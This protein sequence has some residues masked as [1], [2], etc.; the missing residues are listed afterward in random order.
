MNII[1]NDFEIPVFD[2]Y[3]STTKNKRQTLRAGALYASMT[4]SGSTIYGIF[5]KSTLPEIFEFENARQTLS[6]D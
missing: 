5:E 2:E 3:P 1:H 6:D 4:G